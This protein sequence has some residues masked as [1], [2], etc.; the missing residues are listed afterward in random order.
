MALEYCGEQACFFRGL[1]WDGDGGSGR[2]RTSPPRLIYRGT[3]ELTEDRGTD[4]LD[5]QGNFTFPPSHFV[6][7]PSSRFLT[8]SKEPTGCR[9][10]WEQ[11]AYM[12]RFAF[13][14]TYS[15]KKVPVGFEG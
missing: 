2:E 12:R 7:S 8:K 9:K 14:I 3:D 10:L 15:A 5:T 1:G 6:L 11:K 13:L 4:D